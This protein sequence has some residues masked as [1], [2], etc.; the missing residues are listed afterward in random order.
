MYTAALGAQDV[1]T[2]VV[3]GYN[4]T[5]E[6]ERLRTESLLAKTTAAAC[7]TQTA[8]VNSLRAMLGLRRQFKGTLSVAEV[9]GRDPQESGTSLRIFFDNGSTVLAGRAVLDSSG[10][11]VGLVR[12]VSG[13]TGII[14]TLLSRRLQIP[15][16]VVGKPSAF[17]L[18]VSRDGLSLELTQS[19]KTEKLT[20]GDILVTGLGLPS[21]PPNIPVGMVTAA[22]SPE[23]GLWQEAMVSPLAQW[24]DLE[25]VGVIVD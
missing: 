12:V 9:I 23:G 15:V 18:L 20:P 11:L 21:V 8:E 1:A 19:P 22:S 16:H 6:I 25:V 10:H 17:G 5:S 24:N 4:V 3:L 13:Q 14:D 2:R 7:A